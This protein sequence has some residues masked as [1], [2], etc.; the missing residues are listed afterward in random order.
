MDFN[1]EFFHEFHEYFEGKKYKAY[2]DS[3]R[4]WTIGI[5]HTNTRYPIPF[6]Y[7]SHWT[8]EQ[9]QDAW[10]FDYTHARV[11]ANEWLHGLVIPENLYCALIDLAFNVGQRPKTM[12]VHLQNEDYDLAAKELL[13]WVYCNKKVEIG[14]VKRRL[15]MY[16]KIIGENW[17]EGDYLTATSKNLEPLKKELK[18]LGLEV[19]L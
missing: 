17:K 14:L 6:N 9:V 3:G 16:K 10:L 18:R 2:P 11:M 15:A 1:I 4:T 7:K 8:E 5:G 13:K 12:M 19:P